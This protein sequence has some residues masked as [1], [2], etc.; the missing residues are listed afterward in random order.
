MAKHFIW[1]FLYWAKTGKRSYGYILSK[2]DYHHAL[3][4]Y[5]R[6]QV[7]KTEKDEAGL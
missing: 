3:E 5:K 7:L 2:R 4:R 1:A 6:K